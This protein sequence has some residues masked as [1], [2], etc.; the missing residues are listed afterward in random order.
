MCNNVQVESDSIETVQAC[1]G[2]ESW[3]GES[4]TIFADCID[5][6]IIIGNVKFQ[7]CLREANGVGHKLARACFSDKLSCNRIDEPLI[8]ILGKLINDITI[9]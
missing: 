4:S 5:L 1:T 6:A 3:W 2:E 7:Y 9:M 8:F